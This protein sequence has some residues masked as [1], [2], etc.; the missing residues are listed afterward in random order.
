VNSRD[1]FRVD[2]HVKVLDERVVARAKACG[3]DVLAY[4]PHFVPLPDIRDRAAKFSDDELL[5]VPAREVFT[6]TW[7]N[8][9]HVLAIGLDE[10]VPDFVTLAGAMAEFERQDAAVLI[11]HPEF[12]NVGASEADVRVHADIVDGVETYNPKS[13]ARHNRRAKEI[14]RNTGTPQFASSYAHL[15]WTVGEAWTTLDSPVETEAELVSRIRDGDLGRVVHRTGRGHELWRKAEF[16]HLGWEN[17]WGK[18]DRLVL[19]DRAATHPDEA[20]Y[21]GEFDAVSVY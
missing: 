10:P 17:T 20:L 3:I 11:P 2:V 6:G 12:L 4:A 7:R 15:P 5:V 21:E 19:T 18:F 1:E 14:A 16:A 13:L 8:R 9:K